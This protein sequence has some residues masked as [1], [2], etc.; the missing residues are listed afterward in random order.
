VRLA[1]PIRFLLVTSLLALVGC[2]WVPGSQLRWS[3]SVRTWEEL[4]SGECLN[5]GVYTWAIDAS[6]PPFKGTSSLKIRPP[7]KDQ[8]EFLPTNLDINWYLNDALTP[9]YSQEYDVRN[10][11]AKLREEVGVTW[12]Y[13]AGDDLR[14]EICV[15]GGTLPIQSELGLSLK[16]KFDKD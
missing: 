10:G 13:L 16:W 5:I 14:Y 4:T 11:R 2:D 3:H 7:N 12:S 6:I 15:G 8:R 1:T 9:F